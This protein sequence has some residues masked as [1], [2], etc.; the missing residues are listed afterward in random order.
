MEGLPIRPRPHE[1]CLEGS[2][3]LAR[4]VQLQCTNLERYEDTGSIGCG[5]PA[6]QWCDSGSYRCQLALETGLQVP[7]ISGFSTPL[8]VGPSGVRV[9]WVAVEQPLADG[10]LG[11]LWAALPQGDINDPCR[12]TV[13]FLW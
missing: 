6:S 2:V 9:C 3:L 10:G 4:F 11:W 13:S 12:G 5:E 1:G 7:F 8:G